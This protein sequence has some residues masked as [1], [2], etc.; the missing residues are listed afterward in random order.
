MKRTGRD[1]LAARRW[2]VRRWHGLMSR[3][4]VYLVVVLS[5]CGPSS[6][7]TQTGSVA[8]TSDVPSQATARP[9]EGIPPTRVVDQTPTAGAV[10]TQTA[11]LVDE[12]PTVA[13]ESTTGANVSEGS[14]AV[15]DANAAP[16]T[17]VMEE[18][19]LE[20]EHF[21]AIGDPNAPLTVI[22]FSDYG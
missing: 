2:I 12:T 3:A 8:Q 5:A 21:A 19:G 11:E 15:V 4:L 16:V 6:P 9:T 17:A 10:L 13:A 22:E 1:V 7:N 18:L 14:T 20:G